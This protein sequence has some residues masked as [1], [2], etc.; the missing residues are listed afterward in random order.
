MTCPKCGREYPINELQNLCNCGAPLLAYIQVEAETNPL[1]MIITE[2]ESLWRYRKLLPIKNEN[3]RVTLGEGMTPLKREA[4]LG[5]L[6]GLDNLYLKDEGVNPTG[7]FKDRGMTVALSRA[8]ELGVTKV[9]L[10]SAGNAGVAAAAYAD[11]AGMECWVFIPDDT[12]SSFS[13]SCLEYGANVTMVKGTITDAGLMMSETLDESWFNLSTLKEPYRVEGKKTMGYELAEQL[14]WKLPDVI[15]YPTGGGTGLIGMWKAFDEMEKLGWIDGERPKMVSVQSE[16]CAPIVKAF[17][18]GKDFAE[19]WDNAKTNALG[20]RVPS[21][22]GDF[23][24]LRALRES[25]GTAIAVSEDEIIEGIR[26]VEKH[27]KL[28]PAPEGG[29]AVI[30][31][32][33]LVENDF[34]EGTESV[35]VFITGS[36]EKYSEL[37]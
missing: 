34:L 11:A 9:S 2:D 36:K 8:K 32:R 24:M 28:S 17:H 26:L 37:Y 18:D 5:S 21:A 12:P 14:D 27:T 30:A 22:V 29:A 20:L 10:P 4:E 1:E 35:V 13:K 16:G 33:K 25:G 6:L 3:D 19:P 23:L 31:A 7:S 15:I